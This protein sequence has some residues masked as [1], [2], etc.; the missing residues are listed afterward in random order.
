MFHS[1]K[2]LLRSAAPAAYSDVSASLAAP[3]KP[4]SSV[5]LL[6]RL[7]EGRR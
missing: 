3:P 4:T 2:I 7:Q 1:A 5:M 6:I